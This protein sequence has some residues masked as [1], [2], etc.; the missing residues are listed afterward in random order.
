MTQLPAAQLSNWL[1]DSGR[2]Q[3]LLIDVR[4][5]WEYEICRITGSKSMPMSQ[6]A[7]HLESIDASRPIVCICHHG[8]RSGHVAMALEQHGCRDVYNLIGGVDAW[9]REV[10]PAMSVY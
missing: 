5:T 3:P 7:Q 1:A 2:P 8:A 4:E 10:D 9:A 6:I